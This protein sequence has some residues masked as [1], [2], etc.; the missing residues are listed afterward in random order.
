MREVPSG[1]ACAETPATISGVIRAVAGWMLVQPLRGQQSND[2]L[3]LGRVHSIGEL[4]DD[5]SERLPFKPGDRVAWVDG[6]GQAFAVNETLIVLSLNAPVVYE[7][8]EDLVIGNG[9]AIEVEQ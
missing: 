3:R 2:A 8:L 9:R 5:M 4:P 7:P 1:S 6:K